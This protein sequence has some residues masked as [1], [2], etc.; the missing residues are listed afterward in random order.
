MK[1]RVIALLGASTALVAA[2]FAS[3]APTIDSPPTPP[4]SR[5]KLDVTLPD[6]D[7]S[8]TLAV[9]NGKPTLALRAP[10]FDIKLTKD[11]TFE[12]YRF[13]DEP[14]APAGWS[15]AWIYR[16]TG[17]PA[18]RSAGG[19]L[20]TITPL[21][22]VLGKY[23]L[24]LDWFA[25]VTLRDKVP[26]TAA[27]LGAKFRL[28]DQLTITASGGFMVTQGNPSGFA[29]GAGIDLKFAGF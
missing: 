27:L 17:D 4:E 26:V 28:A 25:G 13:Q 18:D 5:Y 29:V 19:V 23:T 6:F 12:A 20:K 11:V 1:V 22:N 14:P 21:T 9:V 2:A 16:V 3:G 7:T 15:G 24:T 10:A 8:P